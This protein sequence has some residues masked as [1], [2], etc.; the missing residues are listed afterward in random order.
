MGVTESKPR[1][2]NQRVMYIYDRLNIDA[3][4]KVK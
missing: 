2:L 1:I 3:L 4:D